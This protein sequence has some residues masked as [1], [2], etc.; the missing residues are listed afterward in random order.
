MQENGY[1]TEVV[2]NGGRMITLEVANG[3]KMVMLQRWS[4]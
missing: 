4:V 2:T 1:V 3:G